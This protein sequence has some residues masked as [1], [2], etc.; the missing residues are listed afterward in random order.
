MVWPLGIE[1]GLLPAWI[2]EYQQEQ[3]AVEALLQV[4]YIN[5]GTA[6]AFLEWMVEHDIPP[7]VGALAY[8]YNGG[9][10]SRLWM[11]GESNRFSKEVMRLYQ[12]PTPGPKVGRIG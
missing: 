1:R 6:L 3:K 12:P 2:G 5:E 11:K 10:Y 4:D 8:H 9:P 7:A